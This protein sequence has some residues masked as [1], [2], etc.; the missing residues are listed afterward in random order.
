MLRDAFPSLADD[1]RKFLRQLAAIG[2][3]EKQLERAQRLYLKA[4]QLLG[5]WQR[6]VLVRPDEVSAHS[7]R[8]VDECELQHEAARTDV[9]LSTATA[10]Q[11][12][13]HIYNWAL[14]VAPHH[15]G[16]RIRPRCCDPDV[17]RG[18]FHDL[19]DRPEIGWHPDW[20]TMFR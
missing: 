1:H 5:F 15:E 2:A 18:C 7:K 6:S 10:A 12:G 20:S 8:L 9:K 11:I 17:V 4:T 14:T 13:M 3:N 19:A 16:L